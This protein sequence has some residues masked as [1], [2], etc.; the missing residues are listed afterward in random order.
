MASTEQAHETGVRDREA[1]FIAGQ[2]VQPSG[3]GRIEGPVS[4][5]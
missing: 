3:S 1:L 4:G 5:P 2:W